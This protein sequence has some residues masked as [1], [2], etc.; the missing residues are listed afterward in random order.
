MTTSLANMFHWLLW[1]KD[2]EDQQHFWTNN[3]SS[4]PNPPSNISL[5]KCFQPT[6]EEE[7]KKIILSGNSK[8][9]SLDPL[10]TTLLKELLD[11]LLSTL[12]KLVNAAI[13]QSTIPQS[14]KSAS[15]TPL[16]KKPSLDSDDTKNYRPVS[17][18]PYISKLV[19]KVIVKQLNKHLEDNN[20]HQINQSA[21]R[22]H[23][24]TET[25]LVKI[26][27]FILDALDR[28]QCV[29]LVL[30][31]QSAAFDTVHEDLLIHKLQTMYGITDSALALFRSCFK[32]RSQSVYVNG[33]SSASKFLTTGFPQGSVLGPYMYPLYTSSL[34]AIAE[35]H[36]INIHMYADDTQLYVSFNHLNCHEILHQLESAISEIRV[37]MAANHLKTEWR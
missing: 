4:I 27:D 28:N 15:V 33:K 10:P 25:A 36:G 18:L 7:L 24:S 30:L 11:T 22:K 1:G 13:D 8:A 32:G 31:D 16:I 20:L 37:W 12:T 21:Y 17:N 35:E 34:F 23:H 26:C 9:C 3:Q 2:Q 6:K 29:F 19:E 14:L 5:L